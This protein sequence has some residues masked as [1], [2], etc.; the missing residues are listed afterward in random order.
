[1]KR[2][3]LMLLILAV[4]ISAPGFA[5]S[6]GSDVWVESSC[7]HIW[8]HKGIVLSDYCHVIDNDMHNNQYANKYQCEKCSL[9]ELRLIQG[10][11]LEEKHSKYYRDDGHI[12]GE[13]LHLATNKCSKCNWEAPQM[14]YYCPGPPCV[15]PNVMPY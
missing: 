11:F 13:Q 12:F 4:L 7:S 14:Q 6:I 2:V 5:G 10:Y 9:V 1:M 3:L 8:D 15:Y